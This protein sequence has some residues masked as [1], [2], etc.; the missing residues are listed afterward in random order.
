MLYVIGRTT[1]WVLRLKPTNEII[2]A[3]NQIP[4]VFAWRANA[5]R[6][7]G[8]QML[9]KGFPDIFG[10]VRGRIFF[11]EVKRE[12]ERVSP[13]QDEFMRVHRFKDALCAIVQTPDEAVRAVSLYL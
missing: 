9:P 3:L 1:A 12:G 2:K 7:G 4:S 5:G 10:H 13:E 8:V 6:R 11:L